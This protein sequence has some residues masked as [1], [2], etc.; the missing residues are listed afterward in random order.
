MSKNILVTNDAKHVF[1]DI[2]FER[3][4]EF[5]DSDGEDDEN[6]NEHFL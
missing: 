2:D 1:N 5:S 6:E 3:V 4:V